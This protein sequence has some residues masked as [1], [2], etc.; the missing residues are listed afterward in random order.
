M[1]FDPSGNLELKAVHFDLSDDTK[2][3]IDAKL[4]KIEFAQ[5]YIVDLMIT[6]TKEKSDYVIEVTVNFRWH[7]SAHIKVRAYGLHEGLEQLIDKLAEKVRKEK[8]RIKEHKANGHKVD[9]E[10]HGS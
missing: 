6:M 5:D 3:F 4:E 9:P 2:E 10:V 7:K 1:S 8:D